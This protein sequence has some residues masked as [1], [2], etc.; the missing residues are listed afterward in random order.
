MWILETQIHIFTT[1]FELLFFSPKT[2]HTTCYV[3]FPVP[4][5]I[6]IILFVVLYILSTFIWDFP[7][8]CFLFRVASCYFLIFLAARYIH[9]FFVFLLPLLKRYIFWFYYYYISYF[10]TDEATPIFCL[11]SANF[12]W[13]YK[14]SFF[15][16]F[17]ATM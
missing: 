7:S 13:K 4:L 14:H 17:E 12:N 11:F 2:Y 16:F 3:S 10:F 5:V 8:S 15:S 1:Y 6:P 9:Y